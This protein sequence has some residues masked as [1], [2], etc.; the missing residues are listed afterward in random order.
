MP[1]IQYWLMHKNTKWCPT[2]C[3]DW[4]LKRLTDAHYSVLTVPTYQYWLCPPVSTW[5]CPLVSK[6]CAHQSVLTDSFLIPTHIPVPLYMFLWGRF[7]CSRK[8]AI[9][10]LENW[11]SSYLIP[12]HITVPLLD[13]V[14]Y[15]RLGFVCRG[16]TVI[17]VFSSLHTYQCLWP[18]MHEA[19]VCV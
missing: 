3:T 8:T 14:H 7:V 6:D 1:N 13:Y 19:W 12:T 11:N 2:F 15:M 10:R 16:N 17:A 5:L 4:W 18:S 9:T